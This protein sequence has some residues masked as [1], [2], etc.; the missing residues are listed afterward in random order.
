MPNI[1]D[2]NKIIVKLQSLLLFIAVYTLNALFCQHDFI[3]KEEPKNK[4]EIK[5][6]ER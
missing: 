6:G 4:G 1:F 2:Y 3:K 5:S